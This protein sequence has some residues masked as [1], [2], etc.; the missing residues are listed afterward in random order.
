MRAHNNRPDHLRRPVHPH[1][2]Q[3][4]P[5]RAALRV[6]QFLAQTRHQ[7]RRDAGQIVGR[8]NRFG[9]ALPHADH[10]GRRHW[11]QRFRYTAQRLVQPAQQAGAEPSCQ[12]RAGGSCQLRHRIEPELAQPGRHLHVQPQR[13]YRQRRHRGHGLARGY[14]AH[15]V[16]PVPGQR[17]RAARR[18][19]HRD[20]C[21]DPGLAQPLQHGLQKPCLAAMQ[22]RAPGDV[23]PHAVRPARRRQRAEPHAPAGQ[24]PQC[25]RV[26]RGVCGLN[27]QPWHHRLC[28]RQLHAGVDA[29]AQRPRISRIHQPML[30]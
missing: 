5:A 11:L 10:A 1:E 30:N 4:Q 2:H 15:R 3:I 21:R 7:Q 17:V 28:L 23:D 9:K 6:R 29:Q 26:S 27:A 22:M 20:P 25:R 14:H 19:R 12:R 24:P 13:L 8:R 16:Q 18:V